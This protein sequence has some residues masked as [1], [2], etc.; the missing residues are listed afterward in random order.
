MYI[1]SRDAAAVNE[2]DVRA[3]IIAKRGVYSLYRT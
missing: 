2:L 3:K 1:V